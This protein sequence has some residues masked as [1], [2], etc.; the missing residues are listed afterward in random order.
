[1]QTAAS[2]T[3]NFT[4]THTYWLHPSG[5]WTPQVARFLNE[6]VE[7]H[8]MDH[9]LL[10]CYQHVADKPFNITEW[11][12][13]YPNDYTTE[14]ALFMAAYGALQNVSANDRFDFKAPELV[15]VKEDFFNVFGSP[16]GLAAEPLAYFLYVRG[17]LRPAP[18]IHQEALTEAE[19]FDPF[20]GRDRPQETWWIPNPYF[21]YFGIQTVPR[22]A[23]LVGGVR[24][25][26]DPANYP[27]I[28]DEKAYN[29]AHD[30]QAGTIT[31]LTGELVWDTHGAFV[32]AQTPKAR[33]V[34][35]ALQ[36][37][38]E[39]GPLTMHLS[40]AYGVA[41][42][43]SLDDRALE[44]SRRILLTLA[45]RD[46]NSRQTLEVEAAGDQPAAGPK[47]HRMGLVGAPPL[48]EEPVTV[49]FSLKTV[50]NSAWTVLPVDVCGRPLADRR[51]TLTAADGAL[52]GRICNRDDK[53]LNYILT[54]K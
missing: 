11:N 37:R 23:M 51:R 44:T 6:P 46:R 26:L 12:F 52:A 19:L 40:R 47:R 53:A 54:V 21:V 29:A 27:G 24:L 39:N 45:G 7:R 4:G 2:A 13:C 17:D 41:G 20:R 5:G 36:G 48:I 42:M 9:L 1:M 33:C 22:D 32:Q 8:P 25:S 28:W 14:A 50:Y 34:M 18:I 30:A 16:A 3:L 31:S 38:H 49:D 35:G 10:R 43:A 15:S